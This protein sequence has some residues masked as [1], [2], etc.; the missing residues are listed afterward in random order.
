[1]EQG[2]GMCD[3]ASVREPADDTT[4][5]PTPAATTPAITAS[6]QALS[7]PGVSR[8]HAPQQIQN[9]RVKMANT[10]IGVIPALLLGAGIAF[11]GLQVGQGIERFR[12]ADRTITV[13]GLA[14]RDVQ[15]DFAVWTLS[16]RRAA[17]EFSAVQQALTN[18]RDRV[19][20][21]LRGQGFSDAEIDVRPLQ[22]QDLL[23]REYG[24]DNVALRFNGQGQVTV[25]SARIEAVAAA[26]NKVDPLIAAGIQLGGDGGGDWPSYQLRGFNDIKPQ[27]LEEATRSAREQATKFAAD[28]GASLGPLKSANQG[29]IRILDDDGSDMDSSRTMGKRLRVVSTFQFGLE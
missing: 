29:A 12:M 19:L 28:A 11:A 24:S 20:D 2:R 16:F 6:A 17:N 10:H 4:P 15:S 22:V 13:K 14:E 3:I 26:S 25:K 5:H 18:D 7:R 27:L 8:Y 23:A 21:F 9:G 1:M